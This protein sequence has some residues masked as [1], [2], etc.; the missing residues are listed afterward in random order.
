MNST[1]VLGSVEFGRDAMAWVQA[2]FLPTQCSPSGRVPAWSTE[3]D[4]V[5]ED[6]AMQAWARSLV[7]S[8]ESS[9]T[10]TTCQCLQGGWLLSTL[11]KQRLMFSSS[12]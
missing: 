9:S 4:A 3:A 6:A 8:V 7:A 5:E 2:Q 1:Q 12:L 10:T 11:P